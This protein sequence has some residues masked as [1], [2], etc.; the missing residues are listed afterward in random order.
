MPVHVFGGKDAPPT[1]LH[2]PGGFYRVT[3]RGNHRQD[4]FFRSEDR[5]HLDAI[6]GEVIE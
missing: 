6:V 2:A 1:R 4:I 5:Q 3:L